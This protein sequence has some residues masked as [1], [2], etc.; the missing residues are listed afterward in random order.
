MLLYSGNYDKWVQAGLD[1]EYLPHWLKKAGYKAE[2][3]K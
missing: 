1:E 3:K 2:C